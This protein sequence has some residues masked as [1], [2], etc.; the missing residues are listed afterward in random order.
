MQ[1]RRFLR[2]AAVAALSMSSAARAQQPGRVPLI[3]YLG[4]A[5]PESFAPQL[6]EFRRGLGGHGFVEGRNV[7][8]EYRWADGD[9]AKLPVLAEELVRMR[10]DV[11]TTSGGY[12]PPLTAAG[13][14]DTIPIVATSAAD[15]VESLARPQRNLT[16]AGTQTGALDPKRLELLHA[17]APDATVVAALQYPVALA[18]LPDLAAKYA[19]AVAEAAASLRVR[20][21]TFDTHKEA[22][23]DG[24]FAQ[25][26][27]S[28]AGALLSTANPFLF[29]HHRRILAFAHRSRLPAIYEWAEIARNGGLMA[30]GDSVAALNRRAGDYVGGVLKGAKPADLPIDLPPEIRLTINLKTASETG[31]AFPTSV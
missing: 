27:A 17:A 12:L 8:I 30:Y 25:I 18:A 11:I 5:T 19:R 22:D 29:Q 6:A 26:G 23:F 7:R 16:G 4:F 3:G 15:L 2:S 28:G 10:V 20:L 14:T 13:I 31:F 24:A 21:V 9:R 1:R